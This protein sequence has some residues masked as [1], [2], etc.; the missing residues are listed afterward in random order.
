[1]T[2]ADD[3]LLIVDLV[4]NY[5]AHYDANGLPLAPF[6]S[7]QPPIAAPP[8]SNFPSDLKLDPDGNIIISVYRGHEPARQ[9]RRLWRY[10]LNG[11]ILDPDND[12]TPNEPI[13]SDLEPIGG[14]DWTPSLATLAGDYDGNGSVGPSDYARWRAAFG[15]RVA[16]GNG[17]DGE[18]RWHRRCSRLH[19][20]AQ[21]G[22]PRRR[23]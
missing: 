20:V 5:V 13:V 22:R 14:I 17:A 6:A 2:L 15:R 12:M 4:A 7:I 9:S 23:S 21:R 8:G 16:R 19:P 11:N 1:M 10:D 3:S 18:L